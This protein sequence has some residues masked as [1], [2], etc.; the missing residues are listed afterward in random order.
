MEAD[1]YVANVPDGTSI[2]VDVDRPVQAFAFETV[3]GV[4]GSN[5]IYDI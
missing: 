5:L 3:G 1:L 2:F 4:V